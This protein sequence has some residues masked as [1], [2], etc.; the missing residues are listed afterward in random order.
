M[1][2]IKNFILSSD[3]MLISIEMH[4]SPEIRIGMRVSPEIRIDIHV[5]LLIRIYIHVSLKIRIYI[6]VSIE[7]RIEI[8]V[9]QEIIIDICVL[10]VTSSL[11]GYSHLI[12]HIYMT[13][14]L[15][16]TFQQGHNLKHNAHI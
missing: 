15:L 5:S 14:L 1:C 12:C 9:S 6:H 11:S 4:V 16:I 2:L 3:F 8:Y 13:V 7:I 10:P